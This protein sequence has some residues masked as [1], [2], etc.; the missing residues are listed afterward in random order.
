MLIALVATAVF[1][2]ATPPTGRRTSLADP[3]RAPSRVVA[4]ALSPVG[5]PIDKLRVA[6][7]RHR[8]R[9]P[10]PATLLRGDDT[11]PVFC[12]TVRVTT[13]SRVRRYT[14]R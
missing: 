4:S 14:K 9:G 7:L 12:V 3:F 2:P 5:S 10:H 13:S 11:Q 6:A 1:L 8:L